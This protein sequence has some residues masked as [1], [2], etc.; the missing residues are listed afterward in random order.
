[1]SLTDKA[2]DRAKKNPRLML[3]VL[4]ILHLILISLNRVPGQPDIRYLQVVMM[5]GATPLQWLASHGVS[6]VKSVWTGYFDLRGAKRE[7]EW[8]KTRNS[9][10]ETQIIE[11][12]EKAKLFDQLEALNQSPALSAY[13]R[14]SA[15]VIG[16]DADE[17]FKTVVIDRGSLSGIRKDQPVVT[18][19]GLVGRVI[20]VS[21]ISSRV[22]LVT[23]ERHGAGAVVAQTAENRLVGILKGKTQS[24]SLCELRLVAAAGKLENGEQVLTSGQ[25][26]LYPKGLL[27]GRVK[28]LSDSGAIPPSVDVEPA[29]ALQKLG[30][31]AV[32]LI[33]PEEVRRQYDELI[34]AEREKEKER[35]DKTPDRRRR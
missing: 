33:P 2:K 8:L 21:P 19:E 24:Q 7:N 22:L 30:T 3:L 12:R 17:W 10:L 26:Q 16:R 5:A 28:N 9:Q 29:A 34:K 15:M 27:I 20:N 6:S 32:L 13:Q 25:D 4:V 1:M 14:V 35:Q 11:L 23:D 31:V 18:A